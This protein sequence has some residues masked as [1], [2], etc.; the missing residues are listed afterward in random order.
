MVLHQNMLRTSVLKWAISNFP[1]KKLI[2]INT[3]LLYYVRIFYT[4]YIFQQSLIKKLISDIPACDFLLEK[5]GLWICLIIFSSG[6]IFIQIKIIALKMDKLV[7]YGGYGYLHVNAHVLYLHASKLEMSYYR[8]HHT[9][10]LSFG[11]WMNNICKYLLFQII[12]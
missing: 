9:L 8:N 11:Y 6:L 3:F 10:F 4:C 1:I 7:S 5:Y 2:K 12:N